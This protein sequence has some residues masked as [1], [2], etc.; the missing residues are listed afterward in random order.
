MGNALSL[1]DNHDSSELRR[2]ARRSQHAGQSCHRLALAAIYDGA[3]RSEAAL[4]AG[5][6]RQSSRMYGP[7]KRLNI[8]YYL[9]LL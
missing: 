4:L 2:R 1:R 9:E 3:S 5:T 8:V 6:D 7:D